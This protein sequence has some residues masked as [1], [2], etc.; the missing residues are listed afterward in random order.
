MTRPT[1]SAPP[2]ASKN[3]SAG[4]WPAPPWPRREPN[5]PHLTTHRRVNGRLEHLRGIAL[6]FRNLT[7]YRIRSLLEAGGFRPLT[8][9]LL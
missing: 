6:G 1:R 5:G 3:N 2:G 8:H 4:Y 9:S 7:N